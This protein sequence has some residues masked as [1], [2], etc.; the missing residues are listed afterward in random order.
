LKN[1]LKVEDEFSSDFTVSDTPLSA[2]VAAS[3]GDSVLCDSVST[4]LADS[5]GLCGC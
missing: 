2:T 5:F 3:P 1:L 4:L